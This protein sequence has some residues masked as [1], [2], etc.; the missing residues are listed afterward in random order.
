MVS[1]R[2]VGI[3]LQVVL[4][5]IYCGVTTTVEVTTVEP[6]FIVLWLLY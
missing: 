5:K 1:V 6:L 2:F 3:P 4:F